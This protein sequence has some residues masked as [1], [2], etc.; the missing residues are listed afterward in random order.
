MMKTLVILRHAH[1]DKDLGSEIDNGLS[2]KGQN[3][4]LVL[5]KFFKKRFLSSSRNSFDPKIETSRVSLISSPKKRCIETLEP[6]AL[7]INSEIEISNQLDEAGNHPLRV[8]SFIETLNEVRQDLVIICSHGDWIPLFFEKWI[9]I[10]IHLN[11]GAWAEV[12]FENECRQLTWLIQEFSYFK[13]G[14]S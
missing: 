12:D 5:A 4:A 7:L 2:T 8:K 13:G 9:G 3:Q 6:I 11:K 14:S 1:R 10:P